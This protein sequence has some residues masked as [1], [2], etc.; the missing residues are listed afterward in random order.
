MSACALAPWGE[1]NVCESKRN[2]KPSQIPSRYRAKFIHLGCPVQEF[3]LSSAAKGHKNTRTCHKKFFPLRGRLSLSLS[4]VNYPGMSS[5]RL[6]N[7][8]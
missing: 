6:S 7:A 3:L 1:T 2:V 5:L 4:L 8:D